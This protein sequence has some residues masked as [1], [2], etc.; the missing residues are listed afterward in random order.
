MQQLNIQNVTEEKPGRINRAKAM[1][2][3]L[4]VLSEPEEVLMTYLDRETTVEQTQ[5]TGREHLKQ[6]FGE[7]TIRIF[8]TLEKYQKSPQYQN[9]IGIP[10]QSEAMLMR[11]IQIEEQAHRAELIHKIQSVEQETVQEI[12]TAQLFKTYMPEQIKQVRK[13]TQKQIDRIELVHKQEETS[14]EEEV[15]EEIRGLHRTTRIENEQTSQQVIEKNT[16]QEIVNTR[17]NEFQTRQ[18]EELIRIMT[19][20]VQNQIGAIS[21]Q[22]YGKLEKRM[23]TERRRRGL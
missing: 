4:R 13:E 9:G 7:E 6:V 21:E 19:D 16:S 14:I 10:G 3:A 1:E 5:I 11:D 17:I 12:E 2:D 22:I 23:D 8:E 15:L 18:N 20:K